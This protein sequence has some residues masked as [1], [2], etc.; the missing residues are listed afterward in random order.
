ME[1]FALLY[2]GGEVPDDMQ[3]QNNEEWGDWLD[4]LGE[5]GALVDAGA[6]FSEDGK[7]ISNVD[8]VRDY[9][10]QMDS[11]VTGYT[12]IQAEDIDAAVELAMT[13]PQLP[14]QY[15]SGMV[16]IRKLTVVA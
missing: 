9:D 10:W 14:E 7:V 11:A 6:P 15:G 4:M 16:E 3:E 12:I 5:K 13:C 2:I 1:K 8:L